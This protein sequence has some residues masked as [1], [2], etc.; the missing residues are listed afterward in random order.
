MLACFVTEL[1]AE[2]QHGLHYEVDIKLS[3]LHAPD[4]YAPLLLH[5]LPPVYCFDSFA[6]S[7]ICDKALHVLMRRIGAT[8]KT[9]N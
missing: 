6:M 8:V 5:R 4:P 1:A 3:A 2:R 9:W 7:Q